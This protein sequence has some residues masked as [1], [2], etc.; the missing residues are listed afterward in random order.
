MNA[1]VYIKELDKVFLLYRERI[2]SIEKYITL[3]YEYLLS[4]LKD[5]KRLITRSKEALD[6]FLLH[7]HLATEDGFMARIEALKRLNAI[8]IVKKV[9]KEDP[10]G[11]REEG[12][13]MFANELYNILVNNYIDN[14]YTIDLWRLDSADVIRNTYG[15]SFADCKEALEMAKERFRRF[16]ASK[17]SEGE[18]SYK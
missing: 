1:E 5:D 3:F 6:I 11:N 4:L 17:T 8:A 15:L 2:L 9:D 18:A 7:S 10:K 16:Y 12:I 14:I 13:S